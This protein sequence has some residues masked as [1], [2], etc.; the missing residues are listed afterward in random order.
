MTECGS[1]ST[2][3]AVVLASGALERTVMCQSPDSVYL[4]KKSI[5]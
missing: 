3:A 4:Q 5:S 1:V 2:Y